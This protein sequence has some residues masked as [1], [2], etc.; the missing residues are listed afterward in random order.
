[1]TFDDVEMFRADET[2]QPVEEFIADGARYWQALHAN[3]DRLSIDAQRAA[4][5]GTPT[6]RPYAGVSVTVSGA[7]NHGNQRRPL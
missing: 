4:Q 5:T 1:M 7:N 3:D 2:P 6:W